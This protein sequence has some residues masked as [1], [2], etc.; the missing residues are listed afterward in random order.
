MK[1]TSLVRLFMI[2]TGVTLACHSTSNLSQLETRGG[3]NATSGASCSATAQKAFAAELAN[4]NPNTDCTLIVPKDALSATGLATPYILKA[5]KKSDGPCLEANPNQGAFVEAT[6][7]D[8]DTGTISVYH[9]LVIDEG[10]KPLV[11]PVKPKIPDGAVVGI[12]IGSNAKF[13]R[14]QGAGSSTLD[15]ADCVDGLDGDAF[16]QMSACNAEEFFDAATDDLKSG[17]LVAPPLG[18]AADGL[19]CPT[20]RDFFIV[21]QDQS[22]NV[23]TTYLADACGNTAQNNTKNAAALPQTTLVANGSDNRLL[24][25]VDAA[26]GCTPWQVTDLSGGPATDSLAL[27]ELLA[28]KWQKAPVALVPPGDP[29][30]L[31]DGE[32]DNRQANSSTDKMNLYRALVGQP[33]D[34]STDNQTY[35]TNL[36]AVAAPRIAMNQA[37][38]TAAPSPFPNM[39]NSLY[40]FLAMRFQTSISPPD[41]QG[42]G[43]APMGCTGLLNIPNP[44]TLQKDANGVVISAQIAVQP[45]QSAPPLAPVPDPG[46][47]P[48]PPDSPTGGA[49]TFPPLPPSLASPGPQLAPPLASP[50]PQLAPN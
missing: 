7:Y 3:G 8:P 35:C 43:I 10:T 21:D 9:P 23:I 15:D 2:A 49:P 47:P 29:M 28:M 34:V 38:L 40:T 33:P 25:K 45:T 24:T 4:A 6:I 27:N 31:A 22:D 48:T 20:T 46:F 17:D 41:G 1:S 19:A 50:G 32:V 5:T 39:A 26:I 18:T 11:A 16:G 37:A 36:L 12:W 14:L 13:N 44:V 42:N 30:A